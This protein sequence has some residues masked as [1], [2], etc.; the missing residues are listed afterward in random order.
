MLFK[1]FGGF[2]LGIQLQDIT[3]KPFAKEC[4]IVS[5][6]FPEVFVLGFAILDMTLRPFAE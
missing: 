4:E 3:V 2:L 5:P 6:R 1:I